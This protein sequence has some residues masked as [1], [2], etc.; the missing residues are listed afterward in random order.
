MKTEK[1]LNMLKAELNSLRNEIKEL[2]ED[3]LNFVTGGNAHL[4]A[5]GYNTSNPQDM[6]QGKVAGV[7][8][9]SSEPESASKVI[10]RGE[11]S[12]SLIPLIIGDRKTEKVAIANPADIEDFTVLK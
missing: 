6:L 5:V 3:E 12:F 1:E 2:N 11:R 8:V 9:T 10:I 4:Y 7:A